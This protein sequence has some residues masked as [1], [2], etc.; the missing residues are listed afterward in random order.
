MIAAP[1]RR[2]RT[3]LVRAPGPR[4]AEGLVTH[5]GRAPVDL[6]AARAQH[7]AYVA[8]LDAAGFD[9]RYVE[10]A[11]DCPDAVFVEDTAVVCGDTAILANPGAPERRPEVA[12]T[13]RALREL[14]V[15]VR[16]L[17]EGCTLDGGDVLLAGDTWYVGRSGRTD[18][19][20][21]CR[22]APLM[23]GRRVVGVKV[24]GA[25]H[26][27]T[28]MTAL[29]DGSLIGAPDFVDTSGLPGLRVAPEAAG[30]RVLVLG[31]D[32]VMVAASA[33]RT[34]ARLRAD[35]WRVTVLDI[36]QF[37]AR[38]GSVTCLSILI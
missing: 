24:T 7:D 25:L 4:L 20:A 11:D 13:E 27:K 21:L 19:E 26:L 6:D 33:P 1:A 32:H 36:G 28:A 17:G 35:G 23:P 9:V 5:I 30:A 16:A 15:E 3:A 29:P 10:P 34:A 37:E 12:G 2:G 14:G 8:A 31:E 38:E 18:D 22:F